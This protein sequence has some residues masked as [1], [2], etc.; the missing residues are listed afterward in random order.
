MLIVGN[1]SISLILCNLQPKE[2]CRSELVCKM[3]KRQSIE[4]W[5]LHDKKIR[6]NKSIVSHDPKTRFLRFFR[7]SE[8]AKPIESVAEVH[9]FGH[10]VDLQ[11]DIRIFRKSKDGVKESDLTDYLC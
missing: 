7:S 4:S 3:F 9:D 10:Y 8:Y 1:D 11:D 5:K 2:L 6:V